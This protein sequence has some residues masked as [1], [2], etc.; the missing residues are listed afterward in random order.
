M[1]EEEAEEFIETLRSRLSRNILEE[2][3]KQLAR[4]PTAD[5]RRLLDRALRFER[6]R[7]EKNLMMAIS[8]YDSKRD[9]LIAVAKALL[10]EIGN[11]VRAGFYRLSVW[12]TI[13]RQLD[14]LIDHR[15]SR[16]CRQ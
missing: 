3:R 14:A 1:T 5:R 6:Q 9:D 13:G 15:P 7:I 10:E 8:D 11:D 12:D 4:N 16:W 2:I